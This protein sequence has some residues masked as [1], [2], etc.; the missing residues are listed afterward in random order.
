MVARREILYSSAAPALLRVIPPDA[1]YQI[2]DRPT[3]VRSVLRV[4]HPLAVDRNSRPKSRLRNEE[5]S[6]R[7]IRQMAYLSA[8][9][10]LKM[11]DT[12]GWR[13]P[14]ESRRLLDVPPVMDWARA[15][16]V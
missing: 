15:R 2:R 5:L 12:R 10:S 8:L 11:E 4:L 14:A 9:A 1:H 16:L 6:S 13:T 3:A 7:G